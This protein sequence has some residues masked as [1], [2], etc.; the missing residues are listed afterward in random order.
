[1][2]V[3]NSTLLA[4]CLILGA[5]GAR[6]EGKKPSFEEWFPK[7]RPGTW[8]KV[9]GRMDDKGALYAEELRILD[10]DLDESE[11]ESRVA[12]VDSVQR[13]LRTTFGTEV[14]ATL[15]T[16]MRGPKK[17]RPSF[18]GLRAGDRIDVEGH[19]QKDGRLQADEIKVK[20]PRSHED[21]EA[22]EDQKVK[23]RI[24]SV[25]AKEKK[26]V[27]LGVTVRFDERTKNKTPV[28]D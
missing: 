19:L 3:R 17:A 5:S 27:L 6:G 28:L 9:E 25:D 22:D 1:M 8:V 23:G 13:T 11:L 10:G 21:G 12:A 24:E 2:R 16:E 15:K 18:A 20:K 14:L 4:A 26:I 7:L